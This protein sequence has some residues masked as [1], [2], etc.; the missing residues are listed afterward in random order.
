MAKEQTAAVAAPATPAV[1]KHPTRFNHVFLV[2]VADNGALREV[3][4]VKE[5]ANGTIYY[6]D[7]ASLDNFDKGRLK[8]L[9]TSQHADKYPLWD[10]MSQA[11]LS[12]GKNALDYFHQLVKVKQA[13][14]SVNTA[15]GGG[16]AGV[17]PQNNSMVGSGF[18][19]PTSG[20]TGGESSL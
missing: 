6:V 11:T 13:P 1:V 14:G 4:V 7:I 9:V 20:T 15:L 16:L 18:T 3:A 8:S 12:N 2:D 19:D 10:L 17:M 5:E